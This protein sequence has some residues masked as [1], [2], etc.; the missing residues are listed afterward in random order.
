[1]ITPRKVYTAKLAQKLKEA[2]P[3]T[4]VPIF[5]LREAKET[6]AEEGWMKNGKNK[7][8]QASGQIQRPFAIL[9]PKGSQCSYVFIVHLTFAVVAV[10]VVTYVVKVLCHYTPET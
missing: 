2:F 5:I 7:R 3:G 10:K 4:L 9:I 6:S 1:M 8:T